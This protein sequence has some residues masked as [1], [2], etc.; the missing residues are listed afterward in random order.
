MAISQLWFDNETNIKVK[1]I[2]IKNNSHCEMSINIILSV[3]LHYAKIQTTAVTMI[4]FS[5][6]CNQLT[7]YNRTSN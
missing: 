7:I 5:Y 6:S 4:T 1:I 2:L 3:Y